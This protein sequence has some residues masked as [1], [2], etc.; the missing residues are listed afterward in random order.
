MSPSISRQLLTGLVNPGGYAAWDA[1]K[2]QPRVGL[3][4]VLGLCLCAPDIPARAEGFT[5]A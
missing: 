4:G 2:D 1:A 5:T 3:G